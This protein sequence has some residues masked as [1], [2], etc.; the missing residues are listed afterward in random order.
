MAS[1]LTTATKDGLTLEQ[2]L[3]ANA[4]GIIEQIARDYGVSTLEVVEKLPDMHR[5]L[6]EAAA[7]E[8]I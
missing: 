8:P 3:A 2:R 5:T 1:Q 4:D 7:F 6:A